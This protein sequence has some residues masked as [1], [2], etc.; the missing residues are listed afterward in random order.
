MGRGG[1]ARKLMW[2]CGGEWERGKA[3][4]CVR[5]SPPSPRSVGSYR[6]G[7]GG[8][9]R[10]FGLT[11]LIKGSPQSSQLLMPQFSFLCCKNGHSQ[12]CP[13]HR[14]PV[15]IS[16]RCS[17]SWQTSTAARP[18]SGS[19]PARPSNRGMNHKWRE[20]SGFPPLSLRILKLFGLL[21]GRGCWEENKV[22]PKKRDHM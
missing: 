14:A 1:E 5:E 17:N 18:P 6:V 12:D 2:C 10:L 21:A 7:S 11:F 15:N 13:P 22:A 3:G 16:V 20:K 9:I 8:N 19:S 4:L